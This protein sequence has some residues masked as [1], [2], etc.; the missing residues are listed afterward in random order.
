MSYNCNLY[1]R[2]IINVSECADIVTRH[3]EQIENYSRSL[4]ENFFFSGH[5]IKQ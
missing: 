2:E 3:V 5:K 1:G 4:S